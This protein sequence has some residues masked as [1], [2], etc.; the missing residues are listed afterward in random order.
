MVAPELNDP[1]K[2][3]SLIKSDSSALCV[4]PVEVDRGNCL[5]ISWTKSM[6]ASYIRIALGVCPGV[7][8]PAPKHCSPHSVF[9]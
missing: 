3:N 1:E 4:L 6:S 8:H 9:N 2:K 5:G 7:Q